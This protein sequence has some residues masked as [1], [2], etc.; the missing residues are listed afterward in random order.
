MVHH[1]GNAAGNEIITDRDRDRVR[2]MD[3]ERDRGSVIRSSFT[4]TGDDSNAVTVHQFPNQPLR[5]TASGVLVRKMGKVR[6]EE[7]GGG[8]MVGGKLS[9]SQ[10]QS[11]GEGLEE[12]LF[13]VGSGTAVVVHR[14]ANDN[15]GV[16]L[17]L[18]EAR[19]RDKAR[20]P[21]QWY[22]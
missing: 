13:D 15:K 11:G 1:A 2:D 16:K 9:Q 7:E 8:R 20:V 17:S 18:Q 10:I 5:R 12:S 4:F 22:K 21:G 3:R 14:H 19:R 6:E